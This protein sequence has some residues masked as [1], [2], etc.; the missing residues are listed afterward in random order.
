MQPAEQWSEAEEINHWIYEQMNHDY[1]WCDELPDSASCDFKTTPKEFFESL[2]SDNDRFSY[3][4][5]KTERDVSSAN[6]GFAYQP[7]VT[8][9]GEIVW[10]VLYVSS[11]TI[12]HILHRGDIVKPSGISAGKVELVKYEYDEKGNIKTTPVEYPAG[13]TRAKKNETVQLDSVYCING[14]KIGYLCYLEYDSPDDLFSSFEKFSDAQIDNLVLD[15][16]YNPGGL[17]STC[18]KLCSLIIPSNGY[19]KL[20]QQCS[21]NDIIA[22]ENLE[23]YGD[24]RTYSYFDTPVTSGA[25]L[26]RQF[27]YLDLPSVY[28]LTSR[29]TASSSEATIISL[30]P[31]MKVTVIGEPTVGKGVGMYTITSR[32]HKYALVPITFRFYNSEGE[33]VPEDGIIP[34]YYIPD[35]YATH[36]KELGDLREPLLAKAMELITNTVLQ[37]E[38]EKNNPARNIKRELSLIP[39]GEPSY[40]TEFKNKHYYEND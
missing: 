13:K 31:Y 15:L 7:Y 9:T 32:K 30:R 39:V 34:D 37:E 21:Y 35:G 40:V 22:K 12:K 16:R 38:G 23:K 20:F 29:N 28:I 8:R 18:K 36:K 4:S 14:K 2:L 6:L 19:G 5:V 3:L 10:E 25:I 24:E 1:L 26:G 27:S 33:T 11:S 17:V